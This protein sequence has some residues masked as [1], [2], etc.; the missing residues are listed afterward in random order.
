[1]RIVNKIILPVLILLTILLSCACNNNESSAAPSTVSKNTT[2]TQQ[3]KTESSKS[4]EIKKETASSKTEEKIESISEK[5]TEDKKD[6][7]LNNEYITRFGTVNKVTYPAFSFNYPDN[8]KVVKEDVE[9]ESEMVELE[10]DEGARVTFLYCCSKIQGGG[11]SVNMARVNISKVTN[12]QFVPDYVQATDY[13]NLGEFM[14]ARL[15]TTG[16]MNMQTDKEFTDVDGDVSYA[17]LPLS[18]QGTR[19]NV[20]KATSGEF[21]FWYAGSIS[22]V[23]FDTGNDFTQQEQKEVI[24][25][26]NSFRIA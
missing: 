3:N 14:V 23:G 22:F 13:S 21:T 6:I 18:E 24:A 25:I 20:R 12:S 9:H 26:L 8:W 17:V 16:V 2:E 11:S 7:I 10:N 1:M 4:E 15:K 19:E 5:S